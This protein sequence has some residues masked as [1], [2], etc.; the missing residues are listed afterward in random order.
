MVFMRQSAKSSQ[1]L[2]IKVEGKIVDVF[3]DSVLTECGKNVADTKIRRMG[4]K[5]P[6]KGVTETKF[7][8]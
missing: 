8:S 4:N 3:S 2:K 6:K 7:G 5:I 1:F